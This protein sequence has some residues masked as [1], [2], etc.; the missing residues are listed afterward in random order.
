MLKR[1]YPM[2]D[3]GLRAADISVDHPGVVKNY[4]AA[5]AIA[6]RET[7]GEGDTEELRKA[8]VHYRTL[9]DELLGVVP[10]RVDSVPVVSGVAVRS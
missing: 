3:F 6:V 4:R 7:R 2:G 1:G 10:G 9:F 5:H 8:V